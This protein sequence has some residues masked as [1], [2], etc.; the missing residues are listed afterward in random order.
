[1]GWNTIRQDF[2]G[3]DWTELDWTGYGL[4]F[5]FGFGLFD[6]DWFGENR[7]GLIRI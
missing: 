6:F 1:M 4:A 5:G 7:I 3:L 2:V